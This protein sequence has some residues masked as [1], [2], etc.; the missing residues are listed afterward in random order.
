VVI[1]RTLIPGVE[2]DGRGEGKK[3]GDRTREEEMGMEG[4]ES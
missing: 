4:K 3:G 2:G 1:P